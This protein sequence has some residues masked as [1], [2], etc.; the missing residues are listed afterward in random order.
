MKGS[1]LLVTVLFVPIFPL[2]FCN[3][4]IERSKMVRLPW[5]IDFVASC[6]C[7]DQ[8]SYQSSERALLFLFIKFYFYVPEFIS[9]SFFGF[10]LC[11]FVYCFLLV[12]FIFP[13]FLLSLATISFLLATSYVLFSVL[14]VLNLSRFKDLFHFLFGCWLQSQNYKKERWFFDRTILTMTAV[15]H[16]PWSPLMDL[17]RWMP[18]FDDV[19]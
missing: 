15:F 8:Q 10:L 11:F 13:V 7:Y 12:V 4:A 1:C 3:C 9:Y 6:W 14:F 2:W 5:R 17:L 18:I 19:F 16:Q